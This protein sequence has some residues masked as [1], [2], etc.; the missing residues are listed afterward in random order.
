MSSTNIGYPQ[1]TSSDHTFPP[2]PRYDS[3]GKKVPIWDAVEVDIRED[4]KNSLE[5]QPSWKSWISKPISWSSMR[6]KPVG[7]LL[8]V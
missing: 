1:W 4:E 2:P 5:K 6:K 8:C 7:T 3:N